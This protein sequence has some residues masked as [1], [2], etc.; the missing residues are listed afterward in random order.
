MTLPKLT[1]C[2]FSTEDMQNIFSDQACVQ[3]M[4]DFEAALAQAEARHGVIPAGA[5]PAIA[6]RCDAATIEWRN[7]RMRPKRPATWRFR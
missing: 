3:R 7:W 5:A 1:A 6:R 4:L 2:M